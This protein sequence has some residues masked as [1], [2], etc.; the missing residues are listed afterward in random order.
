MS[1]I[2]EKSQ[3]LFILLWILDSQMGRPPSKH[4][5]PLICLWVIDNLQLNFRRSLWISVWLKPNKLDVC[6]II[7]EFF[8]D[9]SAVTGSNK[10]YLFFDVV[11]VIT[12]DILKTTMVDKL[13]NDLEGMEAS[14]ERLLALIDDVY[15]YVDGVVV[16]NLYPQP[17]FHSPLHNFEFHMPCHF[18]KVMW[19]RITTM[20]DSFLMHCLQFRKC[21]QLFSTKFSMIKYK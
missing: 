8:Y 17:V 3:I 20:G 9:R 16:R 7:D 6:F 12:V 14:M 21:L 10:I 11:P 13:P 4:I 5:F 2:P 1:S 19:L 15:K 18:R